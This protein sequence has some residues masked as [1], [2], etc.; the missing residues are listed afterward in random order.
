MS[1]NFI[2]HYKICYKFYELHNESKDSTSKSIHFL[3]IQKARL[4]AYTLSLYK[5]MP[6]VN[7]MSNGEHVDG[8]LAKSVDI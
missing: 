8:G 7:E 2:S 5:F 1:K 4:N 3:H 6:T